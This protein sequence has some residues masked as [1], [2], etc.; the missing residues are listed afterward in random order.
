M[1]SGIDAAA[2]GM[3]SILN[4]TDIIANNLANVNTKGFKELI[5]AFKNLH[6]VEL[7]EKS[8][9]NMGRTQGNTIGKLS[10]GS[11]LDATVLDLKQGT[12]NQTGNKLDFALN[13]DG[14]FAI[15]NNNSEYYTR[16]G[17]FTLNEENVLVTTD[18][19]PVLNKEGNPLIVDT[20]NHN[21]DKLTLTND[22][23]LYQ[24]KKEIGKLKIVSFD[25]SSDI[26][27]VGNSMFKAVEGATPKEAASCKVSQGYIENSN[28]GAIGN[29]INTITAARTYESLSKVIKTTENTLSKAVNEVGRVR[30]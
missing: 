14:F 3:I 28:A 13:G 20:L 26:V 1:V 6:D 5:P 16:N 15:N 22:G 8:T 2:S 12:L 4:M 19:N 7:K 24:D 29:M 18:G 21:L 9:D 25:K 30:E 11:A 17:S 27:N 23:T 10:S